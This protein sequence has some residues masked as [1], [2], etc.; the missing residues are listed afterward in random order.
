MVARELLGARSEWRVWEGEFGALPPF[1]ISENTL[2]VSYNA[3]VEIG[4]FL[5]LGWPMPARGVDA[6]VEYRLLINET[7]PKLPNGQT[8][9][10]PPAKFE[11]AL[12]A[13]GLVHNSSAIKG[14]IAADIGN[15]RWRGKWSPETI[16]KYVADDARHLAELLKAMLRGHTQRFTDGAVRRRLKP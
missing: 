1:D 7:R 10:S 14:E 15:A 13:Y 11:H 9:P 8:A 12:A 4:C 2:F 5:A 6:L 3:A 16:L